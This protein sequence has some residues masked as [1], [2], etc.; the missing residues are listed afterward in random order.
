M[1]SDY[2]NRQN[3]ITS[4]QNHVV[5]MQSRDSLS[6]GVAIIDSLSGDVSRGSRI[7]P[8][9]VGG[10]NTISNP[11]F[12]VKSAQFAGMYGAMLG[13]TRSGSGPTTNVFGTGLNRQNKF[14]VDL[15]DVA[16]IKD[17]QGKRIANSDS[18]IG[19]KQRGFLNSYINRKNQEKN[20]QSEGDVFSDGV[21][22]I[23]KNRQ[24][25]SHSK[26]IT[27]CAVNSRTA[28]SEDNRISAGLVQSPEWSSNHE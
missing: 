9:R 1:T 2:S 14:G 6:A 24:E 3:E 20:H 8:R 16:P 11:G 21:F 26:E 7:S 5:L 10:T 23:G 25:H 17:A 27:K 28:C 15:L 12:L 13:T 19:K 18:F 4:A 22:R